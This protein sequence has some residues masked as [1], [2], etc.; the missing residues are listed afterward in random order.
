MTERDLPQLLVP[1]RLG[2]AFWTEEVT[3]VVI[4]HPNGDRVVDQPK[5]VSKLPEVNVGVPVGEG[6]LL[7]GGLVGAI[8][9]QLV[10]RVI[11]QR[12][13]QDVHSVPPVAASHRCLD[14]SQ[15]RAGLRSGQRQRVPGCPIG[16]TSTEGVVDATGRVFNTSRGSQTTHPGLYVTDASIIPGPLAVQPTL[17]IVALALKSAAAMRNAPQ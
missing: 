3:L 17:T 2:S 6:D 11:G 12:L 13:I 7:T 14:P 9:P 16:P 15:P 8:S 10:P 1:G 4:D 5:V